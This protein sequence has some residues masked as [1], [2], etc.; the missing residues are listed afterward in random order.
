VT[1]VKGDA[2]DDSAVS[3]LCQKVLDEAGRLD[4]YYSNGGICTWKPLAYTS[5]EDFM[6][7]IKINSGSAFLALKHGSRAMA[8]TSAGKP[9]SGGSIIFTS[10]LAGMKGNGGSVDCTINSIAMTGAA[11]LAGQNIRVNSIC[12]GMIDTNMLAGV[13]D[14][15]EAEGKRNRL[16]WATPLQRHA[17]PAE[18]ATTALFLASDDSSYVNGQSFVVDGGLGGGVPAVD[19]PL[20]KMAK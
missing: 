12:P 18:I 6:N 9:D 10:S 17:L 5:F 3:S 4:V 15:Y 8:V 13:F 11:Q 1:I 20:S 7:T 19:E 14:A 16:G 2:S